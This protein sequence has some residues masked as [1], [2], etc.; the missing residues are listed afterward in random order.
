MRR[1]KKWLGVLL[2]TF[3]LVTGT[4]PLQA[5]TNE[6]SK[7]RN[8]YLQNRDKTL[9]WADDI[10][11]VEAIGL[12]VEDKSNGFDVSEFLETDFSSLNAGALG[13]AIMAICLMEMNPRDVNGEDLVAMLEGYYQ[14]DGSFASTN[15]SEYASIYS[16]PFDVIALK[17]VGSTLD[18]SKTVTYFTS[19]QDVSGAFGYEFNGFHPDFAA[20]AWVMMAFHYLGEQA[21]VNKIVQYLDDEIDNTVH[22]WN[23][24]GGVDANTQASVLWSLY[25]V[26]NKNYTKEYEALVTLQT[27][28]GGFR[29]DLSRDDV[30]DNLSTQQA[31]LAVGTHHQGSLF[32]KAK[33][34]YT[35]AITPPVKDQTITSDSGEVMITGNIPSGATIRSQVVKDTKDL[36]KALQDVLHVTAKNMY[37]LDIHLVDAT[38]AVIQPNGNVRVKVKIP[39]GFTTGFDVYRQE[40]DG[41]LTKL[42]YQIDGE[43]VIFETSHFSKYAFVEVKVDDDV[44]TDTL[45]I[46]KTSDSS[47]IFISCGMLLL[48]GFFIYRNT[49]K[50]EEYIK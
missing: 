29:Y 38:N 3:V 4:I 45:D 28:D 21:N 35:V 37:V 31:M 30:A 41:T 42:T 39:E 22:G 8:Y 34:E 49:L 13:K 5:S 47:A 14:A 1:M 11:A 19:Q 25:E 32:E 10:L 36:E 46:V 7:A 23:Q 40:T 12:E 26:G 48:S 16:V 18:M 50:K 2:A 17:I 24:Y 27:S 43:Y 15:P 20:T 9:S 6:L 44:K 33:A